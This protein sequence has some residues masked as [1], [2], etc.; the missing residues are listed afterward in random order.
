MGGRS[1]LRLV[2]I[3]E[4]SMVT[5][6]DFSGA[7]GGALGHDF[8]PESGAIA[9]YL[10]APVE[11]S[12]YDP[13]FYLAAPWKLTPTLIVPSWQSYRATVFWDEDL[14]VFITSEPCSEQAD[15]VQAFTIEGTVTC[16]E[17]PP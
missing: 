13:G 10:S 14:G 2:N 16:V 9:F 1:V 11:F 15:N 7:G 6:Y 3:D 5:I 12:K 4:G 8:D 17:P